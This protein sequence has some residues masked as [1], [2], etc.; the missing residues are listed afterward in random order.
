MIPK[1]IHYCWFGGNEKPELINKCIESWK[2]Y[3]PDFE[4]MEWNE[5][6]FDVNSYQFTRSA[7]EKKKW[8]FVSDVARL[9][10]LIEY[11]GFYMDTDVEVKTEDP[12]SQFC[13]YENVFVFETERRINTGLFCGCEKDSE[14]FKLMLDEYKNIDYTGEVSQ[15]NTSINFYVLCN[16]FPDLILNNETQ[17]I[18]DTYFWSMKEYGNVMRHYANHS[19]LEDKVEFKVKWKNTKIRRFL[20]NPKIYQALGKRS[21]KLMNAYEFLTYDLPDMGVGYF[22]KRKLKKYRK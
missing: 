18:G 8:A 14:I 2:K 5:E 15:L 9:E 6:N 1:I 20:R 7:Y 3:L 4:I 10:A 12:I 21:F 13:G 22:I 19:W 11:G 16:F 17:K